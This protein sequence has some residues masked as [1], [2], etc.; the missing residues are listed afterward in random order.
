MMRAGSP[1]LLVVTAGQRIGAWCRETAVLAP[2]G[3]GPGTGP[4]G[5]QVNKTAASSRDPAPATSA[6]P[7]G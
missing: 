2:H 1:A 6:P 5:F 7:G 4:N 3:R